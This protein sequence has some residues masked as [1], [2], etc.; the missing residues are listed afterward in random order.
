MVAK[1]ITHNVLFHTLED[2]M[3]ALKQEILM[4]F[5]IRQ[6]GSALSLFVFM[7]LQ[8]GNDISY[9][10]LFLQSMQFDLDWR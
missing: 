4:P 6:T 7:T 1:E 9:L 3:D 10:A 2:M 5:Y 8:G